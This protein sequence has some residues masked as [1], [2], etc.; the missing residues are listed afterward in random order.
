MNKDFDIIKIHKYINA[1]NFDEINLL[2]AF[3][4]IIENNISLDDIDL[5]LDNY[6]VYNLVYFNKFS[7]LKKLF[8]I[9]GIKLDFIDKYHNKN[10]LFYPLQNNNLDIFKL[11]LDYNKK[12][13][14][15]NIVNLEDTNKLTPLFYLNELD[16]SIDFFKL[17]LDESNLLY[18]D[19]NNDGNN[20]MHNL[21]LKKRIDIINYIFSKKDNINSLI[22]ITNNKGESLLHY[23]V[24]IQDIDIINILLDNNCNINHQDIDNEYTILHYSII[25]NSNKI[26]NILLN[27]KNIDINI[28]DIYGNTP[29]HYAII[30]K[31]YNIINSLIS[32]KLININ[33]WNINSKMPLHL[34]L[35]NDLDNTNILFFLIKNTD[36]NFQDNNNNSSLHLLF[37]KYNSDI[38]NFKNILINKKL[39]IILQNSN[40]ETPINYINK[41]YINDIIEVVS[42]SYYNQLINNKDETNL[43][44]DEWENN[45]DNKNICLDKIKKKITKL[46]ELN[47][48]TCDLKSYPIKKNNICINI[49]LN[50]NPDVKFCTFT[51]STL[52]VLLGLIYLLKKYKSSCGVLSNNTIEFMNFEYINFELIWN[53]ISLSSID[54]FETLLSKCSNNKTIRFII[55][56]LGI[57][58]SKGSHSNYL[59]I[60]KKLNEIE[61]FEPHGSG[62]PFQFNYNSNLLDEKLSELFINK[63]NY[64]SP[65]LFLPKIG[66]Q[67]FD[68]LDKKNKHIGD[69]NGF[70]ALWSIFYTDIRLKYP[71]Y[72]REIIIEYIIK[73]IKE[74][75]LSFKNLIRNYSLNIITI[76]DEI[77]SKYNI[78]INNWINDNIPTNK[79]LEITNEIKNIISTF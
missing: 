65:K 7:L 58:L 28:Q 30:E 16:A 14:G 9:D 36:L 53:G 27:N 61:R 38:I 72:K 17:I 50:T 21:I 11:L 34:Y 5:N 25:L 23:A 45:C 31:N 78:D 4:Y 39:N 40:N 42:E 64:I 55:I 32:N 74:N 71:D 60:D 52:D 51:G 69:P 18:K 6:I 49:N 37:K 70:C 67:I 44:L 41:N 15:V 56:P 33:L 54:N 62:S 24:S 12:T 66:I 59:I 77:F 57:E 20:I 2:K 10:I 29:L 48:D 76:R 35:E 22:N 13:V 63:Y 79:I 19:K 1:N 46:V 75:K 73:S 47:N 3:D 26:I 8:Q 68:I 43:W